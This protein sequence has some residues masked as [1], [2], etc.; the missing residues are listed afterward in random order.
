MTFLMLIFR[1]SDVGIWTR[2]KRTD[3]VIFDIG[4]FSFN[5]NGHKEG[6]KFTKF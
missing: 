1:F 3:K 6:T 2:A 4:I 5:H